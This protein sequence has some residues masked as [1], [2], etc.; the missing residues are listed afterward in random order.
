VTGEPVIALDAY[1]SIGFVGAGRLGTSVASAL[2]RAEFRVVAVSSRS[3]LSLEAFAERVPGCVPVPT[4]Q[5]VADIADIVFITTPDAVI[6]PACS[7]ISWRS[8]QAVIHC[9]G[10]RP[11]SDLISAQESGARTGGVHPLQT[12]PNR[13]SA[14]LISGASAAVGSDDPVLLDWL[15]KTVYVLGAKL[16]TIRDEHRAAYHASAVMA[17]GLVASLMGLAAEVWAEMGVSRAEALDA[18]RPLT[19]ATV[20]SVG[21]NGLPEAITGPALRG[22][23]EVIRLHLEAMKNQSTGVAHA[24]TALNYDAMPLFEEHDGLSPEAA[25]EIKNLLRQ[26]LESLDRSNPGGTEISGVN[27]RGS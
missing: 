11:V 10:A 2:H 6:E 7:A 15:Q 4:S 27:E 23:V 13:D 18:L 1:T 19:A 9:S 3:D 16:F 20:E 25:E 5:D 21:R 22:D 17:C 8:G 12:F 14:D 26:S 24:Y